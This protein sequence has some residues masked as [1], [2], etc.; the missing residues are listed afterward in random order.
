MNKTT[1]VSLLGAIM[2]EAKT[3]VMATVDKK[4][5]PHMRWMTPTLL[6]GRSGAIYAV[7]SPEFEKVKH[8]SA[9]PQ[10]SWIFQTK[11]LNRIATASGPVNVI[12]NSAMKAEVLEGIG[13]RLNVFWRVNVD[14]SSLV[15]LETVIEEAEYF[16]PMKNIHERISFK[17]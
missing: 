13:R 7:T 15:V 3:A 10:S 6:S 2:D 1:F 11:L 8:L 9:N 12:D 17:E 4:G 14:P 16:E 5:R